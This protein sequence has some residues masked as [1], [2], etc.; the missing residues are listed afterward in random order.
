MRRSVVWLVAIVLL[1]AISCG[2]EIDERENVRASYGAPSKSFQGGGGPFW[3]EVWYYYDTGIGFEFR[4]SAPKCG[5]G[6]DYYLYSRFPIAN[7][8]A[9]SDSTNIPLLENRSKPLSP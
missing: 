6:Y 4:R 7:P 5:G 3:F 1:F 8:S 9:R 2:S